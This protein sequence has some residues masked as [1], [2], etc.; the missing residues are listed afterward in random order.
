MKAHFELTEKELKEIVLAHIQKQLGELQIDS[1]DIHFL[2]KS[3]QNYRSEWE[4]AGVAVTNNTVK[5]IPELKVEI[6]T[7]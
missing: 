3:K 1:K 4:E 7:K 2:V 6:E 5:Y